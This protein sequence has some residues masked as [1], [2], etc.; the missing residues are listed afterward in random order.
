M[1]I[2]IS[3]ERPAPKTNNR[4][5][6]REQRWNAFVRARGYLLASIS[7]YTLRK[8]RLLSGILAHR[9][10]AAERHVPDTAIGWKSKFIL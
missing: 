4:H 3:A 7:S 8:T 10:T 1:R 2:H 9:C 6:E 5:S